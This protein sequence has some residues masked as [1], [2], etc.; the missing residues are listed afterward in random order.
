M[1]NDVEERPEKTTLKPKAVPICTLFADG[2]LKVEGQGIGLIEL[3]KILLSSVASISER[4]L[5]RA[6]AMEHVLTM[7]QQRFDG[8]DPAT[9]KAMTTVLGQNITQAQA[10]D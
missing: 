1:P 9:E 8:F 3:Q 10:E 2:S 7:V 5:Q 4:T 6:A